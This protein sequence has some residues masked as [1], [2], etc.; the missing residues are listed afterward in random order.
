MGKERWL[1]EIEGM[2][3]PQREGERKGAP[4]TRESAINDEDSYRVAYD[5]KNAP[6]S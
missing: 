1:Q 4:P 2:R 6:S 5:P 3:K